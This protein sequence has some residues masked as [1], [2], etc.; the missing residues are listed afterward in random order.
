MRA[1]PLLPPPLTA[2]CAPPAS[3]CA[4]QESHASP[5]H[6]LAANHTDPHMGNLFATVGKDQ[7]TGGC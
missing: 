3:S 6:T 5:V 1:P 7:A 4:L 2:A